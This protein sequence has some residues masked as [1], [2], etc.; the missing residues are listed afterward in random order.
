MTSR[1]PHSRPTL[2]EPEAAAAAE[3]VRSGFVGSGERVAHFESAVSAYMGHSR[4]VATSSG[5]AALQLALLASGIRGGDEV[6]IPAFVCRAVLNAVK[7][8]G[9]VPVL[10]DIDAADLTMSTSDLERRITGKCRAI[11]CVH[12]FGAPANI[13]SVMEIADHHGGIAVIE[14]AA[15][16]LGATLRGSPVGSFA[17]VAVVSFASTKMIT[18]GQGGMVCTDDAFL[19]ARIRSFMDYDCDSIAKTDAA[20]NYQMTDVQAAIGLVQL[21]QLPQFLKRRRDIAAEYAES[22]SG[23]RVRTIVADIEATA[24]HYR[25]IVDA[26]DEAT[27]MQDFLRERGIAARTGIAHFLYDYLL[28]D[29]KQ[30]PVAESLRNRLVSVPIYPSLTDDDVSRICDALRTLGRQ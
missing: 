3:A 17:G 5:T 26:G 25:F 4:G 6:V 23:L 8:V 29:A 15:S 11:I 1:I 18:T 24:S 13:Q 30:F 10:A 9:A 28:L 22:L 14:D 20:F 7:N 12:M 27:S 19:L 21:G 2:G 16:S